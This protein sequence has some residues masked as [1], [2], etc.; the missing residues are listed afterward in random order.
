MRLSA[1]ALATRGNDR[2]CLVLGKKAVNRREG[3]AFLARLRMWDVVFLMEDGPWR[4]S[5]LRNASPLRAGGSGMVHVP[6][7]VMRCVGVRHS[8]NVLW[9]RACAYQQER[10]PPGA[11]TRNASPSREQATIEEGDAF[12]ARLRMW[13][14]VFLMEDGP[15]RASFL[16]NASPLRTGGSGMVRVTDRRSGTVRVLCLASLGSAL[17]GG[18]CP[19]KQMRPTVARHAP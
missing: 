12:L 5:F 14:V 6:P 17:P 9:I 15:W 7:E 18:M 3:D 2:E 11:T 4:A 8:K 19:R 13:D 10:S 1:R 16:R